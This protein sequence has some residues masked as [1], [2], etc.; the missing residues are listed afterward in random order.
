MS[1]GTDQGRR[2]S[3]S[4]RIFTG[5]ALAGAVVAAS[6][7]LLGKSALFDVERVEIYGLHRVTLAEVE[8]RLGFHSGDP[9]LSVNSKKEERNLEILPW[10]QAADIE[11]KWDGLITVDITERRAVALAMVAQDQWA[12][13]DSY[14]RVLTEGLSYPPDLPRL[15]GVHAAGAPGSYMMEDSK[16]LLSVLGAL[17][18]DLAQ[19]IRL[20]RDADGEIL[21]SLASG[22]E[23]VFGDEDRLAAKV[24]V[25]V[26]VLSHLGDQNRD[27]KYIDVSDPSRVNVP[28]KRR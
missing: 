14:G 16:A 15:S 4:R 25:L 8:E 3:G 9:L 12:L 13:I 28:A 1:V 7:V 24:V 17:P 6:Y 22:R 19:G 20:R 5:L 2:L 26:S 10:V 21:G 23:V 27:D 18:S 11:R